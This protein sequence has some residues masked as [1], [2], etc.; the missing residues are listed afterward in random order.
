MISLPAPRYLARYEVMGRG[1]DWMAC[2][3]Q[4][5]TLDTKP[6]RIVER[7]AVFPQREEAQAFVDHLT[8][9][10]MASEA[11]EPEPVT[12]RV[13]R[14]ERSLLLLLGTIIAITVVVLVVAAY[15][16]A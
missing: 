13:I 9:L 12:R 14:P 1:E 3:V 11:Q 2:R 5:A 10:L 8:G 16:Q 6:H 4:E 15:I 7:I